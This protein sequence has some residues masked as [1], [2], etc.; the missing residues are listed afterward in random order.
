[1]QGKNI[2]ITSGPTR[3]IIDD[4]RY[5]TNS[6][7]GE[8][9]VAIA[10][11]SLSRKANVCFVYGKGSL[12]PIVQTKR[13][14]LIEVITVN[15]LIMVLK[16]ELKNV[17]FDVIIHSMAVLDYAP[18]KIYKGKISSAQKKWEMTLIKTPKVVNMFKKIS[19]Q[20]FL[21]SFKLESNISKRE[22]IKRSYNSLLKTKS[23]LVVAN[24]WTSVSSDIHR[25]FIL[26]SS[27]RIKAEFNNKKQI[28]KGVLDI[29]EQKI[30]KFI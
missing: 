20:S 19:L 16:K 6:S 29:I 30:P 9:G 2:L 18:K 14:R 21:I 11:E 22:L 3:G 15:D 5:I 7:S 28:A 10:L 24:D 25:A 23:D 17:H 26:D 1:M 27:G 4:I 8:L 12:L 13:L